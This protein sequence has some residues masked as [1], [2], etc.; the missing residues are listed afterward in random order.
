MRTTDELDH[1]RVVEILHQEH[2]AALKREQSLVD[3]ECEHSQEKFQALT[4]SF[5]VQK[6]ELECRV[7]NAEVSEGY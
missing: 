5:T 3:L 2:M 1:L 6:A 7:E 4:M